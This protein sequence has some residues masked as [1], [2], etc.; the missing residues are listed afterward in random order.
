MTSDAQANVEAELRHAEESLRAA[1]AL[2]GLNLAADAA[3]RIYYAT[4]HAARAL[5]YSIGVA[6]RS[7]EATRS[8]LALHFVR[9]GQLSA[10]RSKDI[11]QLEA[12]RTSGDYDPHF[13]L[14]VAQLA[15]ELEKARRFLADARSL[16]TDFQRS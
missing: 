3:S 8:L 13:A 1:E 11:A 6:P 9:T 4:F 15:P 5:L 7:H 12:L 10:E 14:G 2:L 16:L